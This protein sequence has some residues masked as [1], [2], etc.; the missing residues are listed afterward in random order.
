M[1]KFQTPVEQDLVK[2]ND[3]VEKKKTLHFSH[4]NLAKSERAAI[5][6][7]YKT[8]ADKGGAVVVLNSEAYK[9]E[10]LRQLNDMS[11]YRILKNNPT[12]DFKSQLSHLLDTGQD[13][14]VLTSI[15]LEYLFVDKPV[16]PVFHHL[17]KLHKNTAPIQG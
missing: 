11:K 10:A 15:M 9:I 12:S 7:N 13:M 3:K 17:P 6:K 16:V 14:G 2:L 4:D 8:Q 5:K 1:E